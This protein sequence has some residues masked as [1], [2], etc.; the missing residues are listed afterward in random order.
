[1]ITEHV[2]TIG[3]LVGFVYL[4]LELTV[5]FDVVILGRRCHVIELVR[6]DH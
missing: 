4:W 6:L 5:A 2:L 1:M 3:C